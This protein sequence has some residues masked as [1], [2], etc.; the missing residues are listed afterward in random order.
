MILD[1]KLNN[2]TIISCPMDC[3]MDSPRMTMP[4]GPKYKKVSFHVKD[5]K[6]QIHIR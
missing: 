5:K 2:E 4:F 3:A 6:L 1:I